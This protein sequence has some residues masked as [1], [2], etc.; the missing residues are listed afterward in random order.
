MPIRALIFCGSGCTPFLE[1]TSPKNGIDV[2]LKWLWSLFTFVLPALH[3]CSTLYTVFSWSLSSS[4]YPTTRMSSVMPKMSGMSL[5]ISSIFDWN[6]SPAD[7]APNSICLYLYFWNWHAN[8]V[9]YDDLLS[10]FRLWYPEL[11]SISERYLMLLSFG[12]MSF[13]MGPLCM[14]LINAWFSCDGS[15]HSLTLPAM[16]PLHCFID[17]KQCCNVLLL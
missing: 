10:N 4:S 15:K 3:L 16:A 6:M 2:H 8:V 7:A 1:I 13:N 12:N 17:S 11:A 14:G 5:K 9:S